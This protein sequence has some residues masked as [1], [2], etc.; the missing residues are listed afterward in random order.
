M[1]PNE[2]KYAAPSN[3]RNE[4]TLVSDEV[5]SRSNDISRWKHNVDRK[6]VQSGL[7]ITMG[8]DQDEAPD[9]H[10]QPPP[11]PR[12]ATPS[13]P[14]QARDGPSPSIENSPTYSSPANATLTEETAAVA[15]AGVALSAPATP[16]T[17]Q[18]LMSTISPESPTHFTSLANVHHT[19][20]TSI[21]SRS[22]SS[23]LLLAAD[24]HGSV[25]F[26][27]NSDD[28]NIRA[29][30]AWR[31]TVADI[32]AAHVS[33]ATI[34][35][36]QGYNAELYQDATGEA[37]QPAGTR[38]TRSSSSQTSFDD[39]PN[40]E[41]TMVYGRRDSASTAG[42]GQSMVWQ[43]TNVG[44]NES[45]SGHTRENSTCSRDAQ[46]AEDGKRSM[47]SKLHFNQGPANYGKNKQNLSFARSRGCCRALSK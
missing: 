21:S 35:A 39:V 41:V 12:R 6:S 43:D 11:S 19:P 5:V 47:S 38:V 17:P 36:L 3:S 1:E 28:V 8:G 9:D 33:A 16:S 23:S 46:D 14:S 10:H 45:A 2:K 34:G 40:E 44:G 20:S 26:R 13:T 30:M 24:Q 15:A 18:H 25:H 22:S 7:K 29:Q 4:R 27:G 31:P 42:S 37:M 32:A